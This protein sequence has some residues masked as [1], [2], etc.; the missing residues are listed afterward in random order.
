M[1]ARLN[2]NFITGVEEHKGTVWQVAFFMLPYSPLRLS[3]KRGLF[4]LLS[5]LSPSD[6]GSHNSKVNL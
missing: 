5:D 1:V 3:A 6:F 2:D 4:L